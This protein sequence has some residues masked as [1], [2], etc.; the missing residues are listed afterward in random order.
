MPVILIE[1]DPFVAAFESKLQEPRTGQ[2]NVRRPLMGIA[3]KEA[4]YAYISVVTSTG[5]RVALVDSSSPSGADSE[6]RSGENHNFILQTVQFARQERVQVQETFGDFYTFFFGE[7]PTTASIGGLLVN[8]KDF[9]WKNEFMNN[10][11]R[12]LRGTR[13]V[14]TRSRV[15]LGFDDVVLEGYILNVSNAYSSQSPYLVPF[16]FS[17]LITNYLDLSEGSA[18]YVKTMDEARYTERGTLTE[19]VTGTQ[20]NEGLVDFNLET[21]KWD[22]VTGNQAAEALQD[23]S[24]SISMSG[25]N[26]KEKL[27]LSPSEALIKMDVDAQVQ[28]KGQ[29]RVTALVARARTNPS[30]FPLSGRTDAVVSIE[31]GLRSQTAAAAA[32]IPSQPDLS[33]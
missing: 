21:G 23:A 8:T 10:Y 33:S 14:E 5:E 24:P 4:T 2:F 13:C 3:I 1:K 12:Y 16:S 20:N 30:V 7:R 26:N 9:N 31:K 22:E 29:D 28:E 15:Y 11:E 19:Y 32:V 18:S 27:Y 6:G 17:L 25:L